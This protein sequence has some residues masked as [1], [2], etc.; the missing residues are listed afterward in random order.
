MKFLTALA[1]LTLAAAPAAHAQWGG[2]TAQTAASAYCGARAA[3]QSQQQASKA[4]HAVM[5]GGM[6][7]RFTSNVATIFTSGKAMKH[8]I[9]YQIQQ[10]C[11]EYFGSTS[12][13]T[14]SADEAAATALSWGEF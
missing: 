7:G 3:G 11:P 5:A 8:A 12:A 10:M 9:N 14:I 2:G 6:G 1:A 13:S 4:A